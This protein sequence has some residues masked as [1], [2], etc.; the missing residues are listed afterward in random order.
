MVLE[1]KDIFKKVTDSINV[2]SNIG[3][4]TELGKTYILKSIMPL[5]LCDI[6]KVRWH[7]KYMDFS[8]LKYCGE[9]DTELIYDGVALTSTISAPK[10]YHGT[11]SETKNTT[12]GISQ[13]DL[14]PFVFWNENPEVSESLGSESELTGSESTQRLF[15][16]TLAEYGKEAESYYQDAIYSM[17]ILADYW[18]A[19]A[20]VC[21]DILDISDYKKGN[22][23][24]I[25][26]SDKESKLLGYQFSGVYLD[27]NIKTHKN[28]N[29]KC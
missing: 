21:Y 25:S 6:K 2:S 19:K 11:L 9:N 14:I 17:S 27:F 18:I 20:N 13:S 22:I 29:C 24:R 7:N 15:F 4:R 1:L 28:T 16:L 26:V 10:F 23:H 5:N 3:F 12:N 8:G